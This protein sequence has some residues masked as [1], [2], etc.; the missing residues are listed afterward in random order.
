MDCP[1]GKAR[2]GH[3][4][5][6]SLSLVLAGLNEQ[7][8]VGGQP[9][10]RPCGHAPVEVKPVRAAVECCPR[11][12]EAG[13]RRHRSYRICGDVGSI[14][15]QDAHPAL[16]PGRKRGKQVPFVHASAH[17]PHV[18]ARA[19]HGARVDVCSMQLDARVPSRNGRPDCPGPAAQV[20]NNAGCRKPAALQQSH[21]LVHQQ[22]GPAPGHKDPRLDSDP[23]SVEAGPAKNVLQGLARSA[24][25][26]PV[27]ERCRA[28]RLTDEQPRLIFGKYAS[29]GPQRGNCGGKR[30]GRGDPGNWQ[31]HTFLRAGRFNKP[32]RPG[33]DGVQC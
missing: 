2:R 14:H 6:G 18:A 13:F 9:L 32:S 24:P 19:L 10:Q 28:G 30:V 33:P 7:M 31:G 22:S 1:D 26:N 29:G 11:L 8:P 5:C 23:V 16:E 12:I 3:N 21:C 15:G 25:A 4:G 27:S 17:R 20:N